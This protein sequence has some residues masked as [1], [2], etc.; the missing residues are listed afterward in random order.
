MAN[1]FDYL[2]APNMR[3]QT[4]IKR[5]PSSMGGI[6][7]SGAIGLGTLGAQAKQ[8][9]RYMGRNAQNEALNQF[10]TWAQGGLTNADRLAQQ[11]ANR[12]AALQEQAQRGAIMQNAQMRGVGGSGIEL[13][14]QLAA[15]QGGANRAQEN[16]TSIAAM[17]QQR[18]LQAAG[19]LGDLGSNLVSQNLAERQ[20]QTQKDQYEQALK[21][22]KKQNRWQNVMGVVNGLVGGAASIATGG[23]S[24][25]GRWAS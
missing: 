5:N 6:L 16:Q 20:Y 3:P 18:A 11:S 23:L 25:G 15:Q 14:G 21:M 22:Q 24:S 8:G 17:A 2:V 1:A 13:A 9:A 7:G 19:A 4:A 10:S 12:Q